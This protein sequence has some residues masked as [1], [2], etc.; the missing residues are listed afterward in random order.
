VRSTPDLE[1]P[2]PVRYSIISRPLSVV[3]RRPSNGPAKYCGK[4]P[5]II[6][7][8]CIRD[9]AV[10]WKCGDCL[11]VLCHR[12][13]TDTQTDR[14]TDTQTA[15]TH[16]HFASATPHA[17]CNKLSRAD[18]WYTTRQTLDLLCCSRTFATLNFYK[19]RLD[20]VRVLG[21]WTLLRTVDSR[22][23]RWEIRWRRRPESQSQPQ[24][25]R[26]TNQVN[27]YCPTTA[28]DSDPLCTQTR[29]RITHKTLS[30]CTNS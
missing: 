16:I 8:T 2:S 15:V 28:P 11:C 17:W 14:Q 25:P 7:P 6:P 5:P 20:M 22:S 19:V 9:R 13:G 27:V 1:L 21:T 30:L 29:P 26:P 4:A 18:I 23:Y 10:V 12:R 3:E 24:P